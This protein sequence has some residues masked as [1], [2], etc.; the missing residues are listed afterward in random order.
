MPELAEVE[1]Y[2]KQWDAGLGEAVV[3]VAVHAGKYVFR[4]TD[5]GAIQKNLVD[6]KLLKSARHG[7]QMLFQLSGDNW[8]GVHLGMTGRTHAE[9]AN[10]RP[11]QYDHLVLFQRNRA[12][13][14]T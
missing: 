2:R 9:S 7:K 11:A 5:T 14:F 1:W 4:E 8:L 10:F 3:D 12:L 13:V 6:E